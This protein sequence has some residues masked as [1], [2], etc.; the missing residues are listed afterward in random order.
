MAN[1]K[2]DGNQKPMKGTIY[3]P[4]E[5]QKVL[6]RSMLVMGGKLLFISVLVMS[7]LA[8]WN[9]NIAQ[10]SSAQSLE[11]QEAWLFCF[12]I[13]MKQ[14]SEA[15]WKQ[16]LCVQGRETEYQ[17]GWKLVTFIDLKGLPPLKSV[18]GK[19]KSSI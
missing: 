18:K 12:I 7:T 6:H 16:D 15:E 9:A 3:I 19:S 2:E 17:I 1:W 14:R 10:D 11:L 4:L 13:V 8:Y 5:N